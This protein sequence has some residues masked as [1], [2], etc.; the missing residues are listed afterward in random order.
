MV[1]N[2]DEVR[3]GDRFIQHEPGARWPMFIEV[4]RVGKA[5]WVDIACYTWAVHW[6]KRMPLGLKR[7]LERYHV[8]RKD[9]T[10]ADVVA[11]EPRNSDG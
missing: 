1:A 3:R 8:T 7:F 10:F 9:W 2:P 6:R 5:G 11:S 4:T